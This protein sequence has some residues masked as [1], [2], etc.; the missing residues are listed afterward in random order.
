MTYSISTLRRP[1]TRVRFFHTYL[2]LGFS[3]GLGRTLLFQI[4]KYYLVSPT[5]RHYT[6]S[7]SGTMLRGLSILGAFATDRTLPNEA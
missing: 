1:L 6:F 3:Y 7:P 4:G 5:S 2:L